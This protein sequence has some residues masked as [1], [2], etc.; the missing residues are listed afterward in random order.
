MAEK[1]GISF[2]TEKKK[3]K[4]KKKQKQLFDLENS[5]AFKYILSGVFL[6]FFSSWFFGVFFSFAQEKKTKVMIEKESQQSYMLSYFH[7]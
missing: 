4:R 3:Q 6:C 2:Q 5:C 7:E 1:S